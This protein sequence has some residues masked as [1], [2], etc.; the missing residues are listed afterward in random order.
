MGLDRMIRRPAQVPAGVLRKA[1]P[2]R[3]PDV[4]EAESEG[5]VTLKGP[6]ELR[7]ILGKLVARASSAPITKQYELEEIG[8]FVWSL[9]DGRRTV[10]SISK[11]LQTKYKMNRAEADASLE[12]FLKM[13][14]ERGLIT[15]WVKEGK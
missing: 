8:S 2:T 13:L 4:E 6:A 9:I 10:D 14:A 12:A 3:N 11:N 5:I 7:G 15:L 1:K